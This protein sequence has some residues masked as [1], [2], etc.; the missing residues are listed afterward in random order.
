[1]NIEELFAGIGVVIDDKVFSSNEQEE[2]R[3]IKIVKE[4]EETRKFPLV[5]YADLPD[6]GV[7][8]KLTNVSFLLVDWEIE[9][10]QEELGSGYSQ[11]RR[12]VQVLD[13]I[14]LRRKVMKILQVLP[15]L[16][17]GLFVLVSLVSWMLL[18]GSRIQS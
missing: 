7:L 3:I 8:A 9:P 17:Q 15:A 13:R 1:M 18:A 4:L 2:D 10:K 14:P 5:K 11:A 6:D 16:G 12:E